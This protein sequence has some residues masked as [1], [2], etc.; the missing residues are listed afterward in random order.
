VR[1][2]EVYGTEPIRHATRFSI[3]RTNAYVYPASHTKARD[4][5]A[6]PLGMRIRLKAS[7]DTS[8]FPTPMRRLFDSWK[9]YGLI[10]ADRGGNMY[11]QGTLDPRW[12]NTVL[13]PAFHA[14]DA[15]DFEVIKLGW[16]PSS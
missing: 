2:D 9:T 6:P 15:D 3:R 11:V 5:G 1:Y 12:S 8:R 7:V 13:N 10:V 14:L 16:K 4:S